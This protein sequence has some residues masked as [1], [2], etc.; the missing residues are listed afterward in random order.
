MSLRTEP[1]TARPPAPAPPAL[2]QVTPDYAVTPPRDPDDEPFLVFKRIAVL[3]ARGVGKSALS[4]RVA[5]NRFE[6]HYMLTFQ[7]MYQWHPVVNGVHYDVSILDT[8]GQDENSEFGMRYTTGVDGYVFV[9]SVRDESSY[10]VIKQVNE[11]L[12]VTLNVTERYGTAE[13]PRVLVGNQV[14][15]AHQRQV[16]YEEAAAFAKSEGIPYFETSAFT[17]QNVDKAFNSVLDMIQE[18]LRDSHR[19]APQF[20]EEED[21]EEEV[22]S[23]RLSPQ[24]APSNTICLVQ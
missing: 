5:Q 22:D 15:I 13:V 23:P 18:N 2:A 24:D 8:D 14:D 11:K 4:I 3:G 10:E 6:P 12:L 7:D 1:P 9:F 21:V 19:N 20:S 16:L 17:S